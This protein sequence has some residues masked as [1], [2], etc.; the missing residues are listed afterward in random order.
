MSTWPH[1]HSENFCITARPTRGYTCGPSLWLRFH[2]FRNGFTIKLKIA[3]ILSPNAVFY[4][5]YKQKK[6]S[7]ILIKH[8]S[9]SIAFKGM[10]NMTDFKALLFFMTVAGSVWNELSVLT[11][12]LCPQAEVCLGYLTPRADNFKY[13]HP[14]SSYC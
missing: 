3:F 13:P 9:F 14:N 6:C 2:L 8:S 11:E 7:K 4:T 10:S 12:L 5:P 1:T